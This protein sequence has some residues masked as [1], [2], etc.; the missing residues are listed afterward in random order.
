MCRNQQVSTWSLSF[1]YFKKLF[2]KKQ[3]ILIV[4]IIA[5]YS[6]MEKQVI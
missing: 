3:F 6:N 2:T 4:I 5:V 1:F